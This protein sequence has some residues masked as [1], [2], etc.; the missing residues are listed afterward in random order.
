[1]NIHKI[2]RYIIVGGIFIIPFTP[3]IVANSFFF[4]F[5]TGKGFF[6]RILVELIFGAWLILMATHPHYRPK[7][8]WI[9]WTLT[10]F[11]GVMTIA[12]LVGMNPFKSFWSNY[13][14]MEGLVTLLHLFAYYLVAST[15]LRGERIWNWLWN[16][17]VLA[18]VIIS[19]YGFYQIAGVVKINQGGVRLDATF[20]NAT[21]LAIYMLFHMFLTAYIVASN[22]HVLFYP[23]KSKLY[24]SLLG[25][26]IIIIQGIVLYNTATRGAILGLIGG[27]FITTV[28]IALFEKRA[29]ALRKVSIGI[30]G[31]AVVAVVLFFMV[32]N[33]PRVQQSPVLSRFANISLTETTT[34][35]RFIIWNMA[36]Q[37]F[38][39]R[40][41]LG[42]GQESFNYIFNKNYDPRMYNQEQWFDR[43]HNVILDW[44]IA[45][46]ILGL[47]TY[48]AFYISI[49][50]YI[51]RKE[52]EE[53]VFTVAEKS[54]LTGML[55]GYFIHNLFVFDNLISYIVFFSIAAYVT[56]RTQRL[57]YAGEKNVVVVNRIIAPIAIIVTGVLIFVLNV[58]PIRAN[59]NI[60]QAIVPH[61]S[62]GV[63]TNGAPFNG[64]VTENVQFFKK[65]FDLR[66][67]GTP[68]AREQLLTA[69]EQVITAQYPI[70]AGAD[71]AQLAVDE[72][73][74]QTTINP[75]DARFHILLGSFLSHARR[76]DEAI[77]ELSDGLKLTP[78]K[79]AVL[80]ELAAAH[81][82]KKEYAAAEKLF[83]QAFEL[84]KS[85]EQ[86]RLLYAAGAVYA[87]HANITPELLKPIAST[88]LLMSDYLLQA[89]YATGNKAKVLEIWRQRL[90]R[91]PN[92][93]QNH[94]SMAA[95][96]LFAED[97]KNAVLEL[98]KAIELN[99]DFKAQGEIFI[100]EI[101]AGRNP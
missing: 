15:V 1:M 58:Q 61:A 62:K 28:L 47:G 85:N 3:L 97:R 89:Y 16:T 78:K 64:D 81:V 31:L 99:P 20:G 71:L 70:V 27:I 84:D 38:K 100:K 17:S 35:S 34:K 52:G 98:R 55:V 42:W 59:V 68:E 32:R 7:G 65:V 95:A 79:Q 25:A 48:L 77:K 96:F 88:T 49:I 2:L 14:R 86:A 37:G 51:W 53:H 54:I 63:Q 23:F 75:G 73:K 94:V 45:G 30:L 5:I 74:S 60:I 22:R 11:I 12:D 82:G 41:I 39:E 19:I 69:A 29:P 57:E 6:F 46:G 13:E 87:G 80:F 33:T 9:L 66:T 4:P 72:M 44:L 90:A 43:T 50:W 92:N 93:V 40:P 101:Q 18:S 21:Y 76:Y 24:K 67:F 8:S 36:F 56:A 26:L 10:A 91:D 83:K